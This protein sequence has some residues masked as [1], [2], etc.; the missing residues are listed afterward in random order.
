MQKGKDLKM[1]NGTKLEINLTPPGDQIK[2]T[3]QKTIE[4]PSLLLRSLII[5]CHRYETNMVWWNG[6]QF[7][8]ESNFVVG[9]CSNRY[10]VA[11]Y[12]RI[13]RLRVLWTCHSAWSTFSEYSVR[14]NKSLRDGT[15]KHFTQFKQIN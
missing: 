15:S 8:K 6:E 9:C 11:K 1:I 3:K 4:S 7:L 12:S 5:S 2:Q 14:V 10:R 13:H